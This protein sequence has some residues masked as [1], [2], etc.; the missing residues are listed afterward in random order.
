MARA[1]RNSS[2]AVWTAEEEDER[3]PEVSR[4]SVD[5]FYLESQTKPNL[6]K[7]WIKFFWTWHA[8]QYNTDSAWHRMWRQQRCEEQESFPASLANFAKLS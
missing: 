5:D 1:D 3:R 8:D 6:K 7:N 4:K 2:T